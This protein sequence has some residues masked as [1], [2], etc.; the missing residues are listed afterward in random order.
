MVLAVIAIVN[1][2]NNFLGNKN[3]SNGNH[4]IMYDNTIMVMMIIVRRS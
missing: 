3:T 4:R 2:S 1:D